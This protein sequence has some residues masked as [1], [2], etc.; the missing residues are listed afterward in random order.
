MASEKQFFDPANPFRYRQQWAGSW[1]TLHAGVV[2]S[3]LDMLDELSED[4]LRA[5]LEMPD[6]QKTVRVPIERRLK[7]IE[8]E[9]AQTQAASSAAAIVIGIVVVAILGACAG[10]VLGTIHGAVVAGL[11]HLR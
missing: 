11:T 1:Q 2:E 9:R 6:L 10:D 3:R 4:Q 5:A 8:R 7:R